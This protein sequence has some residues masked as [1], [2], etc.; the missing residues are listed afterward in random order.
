MA[1]AHQRLEPLRALDVGRIVGA[2]ADR[3]DLRHRQRMAPVRARERAGGQHAD[4]DGAHARLVR[5]LHQALVVL[6]RVAG[7]NRHAGRRIERVVADLRHVEGTGAG[8]LQQHRRVAQRRDADVARLALLAHALEGRQR[9]VHELVEGDGVA[10]AARGDGV[11]AVED[12]DM[13]AA[14]AFQAC[15]QGRGDG[16]GGA[17]A[18]SRHDAHLGG[19]DHLGLELGQHPAEVLLGLAVAVERRAVEVVDAELERARHRPLLVGG[20]AARHQAADRA[21]P[22]RKDRDLESGLAKPSAFHLASSRRRRA[23][24]RA[25]PFETRRGG[26]GQGRRA[27]RARA[28]RTVRPGLTSCP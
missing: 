18:L 8:H 22:E 11:V 21:A 3:L 19:D 25:A 27:I 14:E 6:R 4:A 20:L 23:L 28:R 24:V 2:R 17:A 1:L 13:V 15:L 16:V 10:G 7:G 5:D 9:F 26:G 12:V